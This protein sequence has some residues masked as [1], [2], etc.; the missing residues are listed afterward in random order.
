MIC[1]PFDWGSVSLSVVG[2]RAECSHCKI[3]LGVRWEGVVF[4]L[5]R[6][7]SKVVSEELITAP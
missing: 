2:G 3:T 6:R 5:V 4:V 1:N 7:S